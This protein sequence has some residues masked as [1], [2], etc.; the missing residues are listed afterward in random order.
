MSGLVGLISRH[1]P[2][3][4]DDLVDDPGLH[5]QRHFR[6]DGTHDGKMRGDIGIGKQTVGPGGDQGDELEVGK[7]R[8]LALGDAD[9]KQ[10][11]HLGP[12]AHI[13]PEPHLKLRHLGGKRINPVL[14]GQA[15]RLEQQDHGTSPS[16]P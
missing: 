7:A 9:G 2:V 1:L 8:H 13:G 14:R 5:G 12:V 4:A 3:V 6:V 15:P 16:N 10:H 11:V